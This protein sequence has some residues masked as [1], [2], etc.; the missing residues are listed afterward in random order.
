MV[1]I[2]F[3]WSIFSSSSSCFVLQWYSKYC[4]YVEDVLYSP[5]C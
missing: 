3:S 1:H 4:A 2:I 5:F